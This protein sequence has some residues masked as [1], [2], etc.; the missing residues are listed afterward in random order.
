MKKKDLALAARTL[1]SAFMNDPLCVI[2]LK[3]ESTRFE[4][5]REYFRFRIHYGVK[6]GEVYAISDKFEGVA[7]WLPCEKAHVSFWRGLLSG[8]MRLYYKMGIS[9]VN[10]FDEVNHYTTNLRDSVIEPPYLQLSPIGVIPE[11]QGKGLGTRL[12]KPMMKKLDDSNLSCFL[13]TQE[14]RNVAYYQRF[15][16]EIAKETTIPELNLQN[17]VMIREPK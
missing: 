7:V 15:G 14:E 9:N 11:E 10:K 3:D 4:Y 5:L 16:F 12:M 13:E 6:Y 2:I 17:W 8:G 1:A